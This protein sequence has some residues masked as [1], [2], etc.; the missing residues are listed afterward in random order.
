MGKRGSA[1]RLRYGTRV[2]LYCGSSFTARSLR[3]KFCSQ[4]CGQKDWYRRPRTVEARR[5]VVRLRS[6]PTKPCSECGKPCQIS[7]SSRPEPTCHECRRRR[8]PPKPPWVRLVLA[9][10]ACGVKFTQH[11]WGQKYCTP[12]HR[13]APW[14]VKQKKTTERGYGMT[15]QQ[16]RANALAALTPGAACPRCGE[17]LWPDSQPLDLDHSDDR[18]G[19]LGLSHATCN[20]SAGAKN[21]NA[22]RRTS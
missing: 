5:K 19:Y 16:R 4:R 21:G 6:G 10:P 12:E 8:N 7:H 2:C 18:R 11:R 1:P 22:R 14:R 13:P 9:C 15:H 17:P 3:Q 20:R